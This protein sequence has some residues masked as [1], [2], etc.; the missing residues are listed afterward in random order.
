[1]IFFLTATAAITGNNIVRDFFGEHCLKLNL[2]QPSYCMFC[3]N[4]AGLAVVRECIHV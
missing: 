1:M 3:K 2:L 4:V